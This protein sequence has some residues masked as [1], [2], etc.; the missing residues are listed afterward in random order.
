MGK[1]ELLRHFCRDAASSWPPWS[2]TPNS[3]PSSPGLSGGR[4]I[5]TCPPG[6]TFPSWESAF[7]ALADLP[8]VRW[9]YWTNSPISWEPVHPLI[10]QK[11][12]DEKLN[13]RPLLLVL[14]GSYIGMMETEVL[15]YHAPLYGRRAGNL[16]LRPLELN[17][18][19][20]FFPARVLPASWRRAV[21]GGMPYYLSLFDDA[22]TCSPISGGGFSTRDLPRTAAAADGGTAR[23]P[24]LLFPA[25]AIAHGRTCLGESTSGRGLGIPTPRRDT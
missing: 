20:A 14:C 8:T 21:L 15:G 5:R 24:Q 2:P 9:W 11:V 6:F 22:W 10:L 19:P 25:P 4:R 18:V 17:D 1:T 13:G 23:A 12:W 7:Q 16:L 3:S